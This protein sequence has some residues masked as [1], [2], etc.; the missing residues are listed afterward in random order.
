MLKI[1]EA[2]ESIGWTQERLAA[3]MNTTQQTV[4]RWESGQTDVKSTQLKK[5]SH[6]LGVTVS[7][8]MDME[9]AVIE[10]PV[11]ELTTS[12]ERELLSLYRRMEKAQ[13]IALM[14]VAR[15]MAVASEKDGAGMREAEKVAR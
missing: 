9:Y 2:R 6:V 8:L 5:L 4:Q 1:K 11:E 15:S 3:E 13:R 12:E 7:Y 14:E 10:L